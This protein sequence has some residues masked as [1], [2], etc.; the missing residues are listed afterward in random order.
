M[1]TVETTVED[2]IEKGTA[3]YV[4]HPTLLTPGVVCVAKHNRTGFEV[5]G[6]ASPQG[7]MMFDDR[8]NRLSNNPRIS[9]N[10]L[11]DV[12]VV[13]LFRVE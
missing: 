9:W 3:K 2:Y 11:S 12:N 10:E 7:L 6:F 13:S 5:T 1:S 8:R 4:K